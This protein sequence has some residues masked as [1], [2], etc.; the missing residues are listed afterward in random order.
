Q[1]QITDLVKWHYGHTDGADL[2]EKLAVREV[3]RYLVS[4]DVDDVM[5][6]GRVE[7]AAEL[8]SRIQA[9]ADAAELGV[10][11]LFVGLQDIHPPVGVAKD[12]EEVIGA[13]QQK[14]A[15]IL[16]AEGYRQ[17]Q[18]PLAHAAATRLVEEAKA[19]KLQKIQ[20]SIATAG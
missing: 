7:A 20:D 2:L 16:R 14:E 13:V 17:Q 9:E 19:Y 1:F 6:P 3:T 11:I 8:K 4:V 12:F 5:A 15:T 18:I 10:N